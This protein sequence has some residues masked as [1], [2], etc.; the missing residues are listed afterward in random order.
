MLTTISRAPALPLVE[1]TRVAF[2]M[3][4]LFAA[5]S[6]V[7]AH[8]GHAADTVSAMQGLLAGLGHPLGGAD[9]WLAMVAVGL[10]SIVALPMGRRLV[11]AGVFLASLLLG[12]CLAMQGQQGPAVELSVAL[13]VVVMAALMLGAK[14]LSP[15]VGLG[16]VAV[17]GLMHG[18]AHGA[19]LAVGHAAWAYVM[20]FMLT[21]AGLHAVG[22]ASG[23]WLHRQSRWGWRALSVML[24]ASGLVMLASRW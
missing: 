5:S 22:L 16:L 13:S 19:E 9:H 10:W 12:A 7:Q 24:G 23:G 18:Q 3:T 20:G 17:A 15:R 8:P 4:C 6:A 2:T 1:P 21:S 14:T 11:G